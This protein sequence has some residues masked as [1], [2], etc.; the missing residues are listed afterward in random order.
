MSETIKVEPTPIQR[1]LFDVAVELTKLY[2][3]NK[4]VGK[5]E[6]MKE[7][8]LEL[9]NMARDAYHGR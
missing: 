6:E 9:Y 5:V 7:V 2:Y 3:E 1:N 4:P 8:Y